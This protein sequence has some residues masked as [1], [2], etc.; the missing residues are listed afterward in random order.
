MAVTQNTYTGNGNTVLYSFTFPYLATTDVK[1]KLNGSDTTAY[2]L[3]NATTVQMNTAPANGD[4]IIIYR[5]TDN[6]NKKATFYPGSAIKAEDL[7]DNYDQILYT[8]QEVDNNA[9]STLGDTAMQGDFL[10]GPGF[11]LQFEGNTS[12]DFETRLVAAD[13]TADRLITLPNASGTLITS[14]DYPAVRAAVEA[15]SDSNVF[16]DADHSKL[17]NIEANATQ[18]QNSAEIRSLVESATDSN[19]FTDADHTKLNNIESNATADQSASEIVALIADQT[20]APSEIDMEDNEKIK[21]GTGDDLQCYHTGSDSRIVNNGSDLYLYTTGDYEVKI[22]ADSQNAIVCKPDGAVELY[23]DN[24]SKFETTPSGI[25][26]TGEITVGGNDTR[27]AEN[28]LRFKSAGDAFIDHNTTGQDI[29][30]RVSNSSSLDITPVTIHS[31][32]QVDIGG[33]QFYT[34]NNVAMPIDNA[35]FKL[36]ASDDLKLYHTGANS[37][38]QHTG[39][40]NL[41]ID[42]DTDDLVLQAGDD[43]RIQTQG[44]EN[45]IN[46]LGDGAVELYFNNQIKAQ[47]YANGWSTDNLTLTGNAYLADNKKVMLGDGDDLKIYYNGTN[48]YFDSSTG[49]IYLRLNVSG[50][51]QENAIKCTQDGNVEISYDG[52]KKFE[53]LSDGVNVT[54]TLKINGSAIT[55][56]GLGNVVE[57]TTPQ[58]GGNLDSNTRDIHL[59]NS[60]DVALRWQLSGTNKWSIFHNTSSSSNHLEIFDNNGS[61]TAAKF[62]T[63]GA[64]ELYHDN[65]KKFET[66]SFGATVQGGITFGSDTA[67]ANQLHDYEEGTW[68]PTLTFGGNTTGITYSS[69]RGGSYTKIG[70]QVTV[71]FG[72]TLTSKGSA[73]GDATIAGLP[74]AIEDLLSATTAEASGVSCFWNDIAT[75]SANIVFVAMGGTSELEIRNT[76]GAEDD[77]DTMVDSDFENNTAIR[78]SITYFTAT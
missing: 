35:Q 49:H 14:D 37:Y 60:G 78:G 65:A 68:T 52:S 48:S 19:V 57:D 24:N 10:M 8:V 44:N 1:V 22:L 13:P 2:S 76:I 27:L 43:V 77:T 20:I 26:I 67:A 11:G 41:Y 70:R 50:S 18:D 21:L 34:S 75:N 12:D 3:A 6:D 42:G 40:G 66:T 63:N 5:N 73:T 59:N 32:G 7:N 55:T 36:G 71:N 51:S 62:K 25:D 9:M 4:K 72:F 56:G 45:A 28:N 33:M 38:I 31:G 46:C 61:G 47:T 29:K 69:M 58:L 74:F 16:S 53:T 17:N 54:G 23:F 64:V 30:F 15:A 39:T